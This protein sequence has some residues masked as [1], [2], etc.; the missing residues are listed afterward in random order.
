ME[1]GQQ[2]VSTLLQLLAHCMSLLQQVRHTRTEPNTR[3]LSCTTPST[4]REMHRA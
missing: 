4:I 3:S 2:G 1:L